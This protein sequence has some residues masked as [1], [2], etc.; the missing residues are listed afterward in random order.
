MRINNPKN[1]DKVRI[2]LMDS[3]VFVPKSNR[4]DTQNSDVNSAYFLF[5]FIARTINRFKPIAEINI[6]IKR[7][8]WGGITKITKVINR[9]RSSAIIP[10]GGMI[11]ERNFRLKYGIIT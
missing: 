6:K 9:V 8:D 11:K 3:K 7:N 5:N 2:T 4:S 10:R 1:K